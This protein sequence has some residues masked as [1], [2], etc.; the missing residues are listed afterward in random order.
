MGTGQLD[1]VRGAW[2]Q[3]Y[4]I[5]QQ[6]LRTSNPTSKVLATYR[7]GGISYLYTHAGFATSEHLAKTSS[8]KICKVADGSSDF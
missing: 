4:G 1:T 5:N 8:L 6:W 2:Q 3:T 7:S